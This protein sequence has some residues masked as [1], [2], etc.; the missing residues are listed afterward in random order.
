MFV[1]TEIPCKL[2]W[3]THLLSFKHILMFAIWLCTAYSFDKCWQ[4]PSIK[5]PI[6]FI[7]SREKPLTMYVYSEDTAI[8]KMFMEETSSGGMAINEC[9]LQMSVE[10]LPFGGVGSS[11]Y[12]AY[13]GKVNKLL[14][15][16]RIIGNLA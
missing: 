10:S 6:N 8:Q 15:C 11:G 1:V 2:F 7:N 9:L 12:G 14:L 4:V 16:T 3:N 5:L 13:H